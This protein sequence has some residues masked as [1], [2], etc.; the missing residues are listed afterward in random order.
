MALLLTLGPLVSTAQDE[1]S[2]ETFRSHVQRGVELKKDGKLRDAL[3]SFQKAREIADH[4]KLALATGRIHE[5]IG[6]CGA[7]RAEFDQGREDPRS[8]E[9]LKQKFDEAIAA[10][11]ECVDRGVLTVECDPQGASLSVGG[12]TVVCPAEIELPAGEHTIE[13]SAPERQSRSVAVT[14]EP[15]G[16]HHQTIEL[17]VPW[18]KPAVTYVTYGALGLGG[19]FLVGGILSDASA[20]SRQDDMLQASERGDVQATRRLADEAESAQVTTVVLYS[21]AAV[22][23]AGGAALWVYG[24]EAEAFLTEDDAPASAQLHVRPDGAVLEATFRW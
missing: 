10:N 3:A 4:P 11:T 24:P 14:V 20:S 17:G 5:Q 1:E 7:A 23:L 21:A 19:A 8:D 2:V 9:D 6:D 22:F 15:A 13:A 16:Q 18:Q 12:D